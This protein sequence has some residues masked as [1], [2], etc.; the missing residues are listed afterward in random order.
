MHNVPKPVK[1]KSTEV[2]ELIYTD[3]CRPCTNESYSVSKYFLTV[4]DD[5]SGFS[6]VFY[7]KRKLD[8]SITLHAF[9]NYIE[10]QFVKMIKEIY[11]DNSGE[12]IRNKLKD[13]FLKSGVIHKLTPPY[14][15]DSNGIAECFIQIINTIAHSMTI[16]APDFPCLWAEAVN[17]AAY[18]KTR[19]PHTHL[20]SSTTPFEAFHGKRLTISYLKLSGTK[21]YL[22]M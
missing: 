8:T 2:V 7:L 16:A 6:W 5:F 21:C 18:L 17:M 10:R 4:I 9:F 3:I 15:P 22:H 19:L 20:P 1:S 11:I 14:S 13:F 12:Y